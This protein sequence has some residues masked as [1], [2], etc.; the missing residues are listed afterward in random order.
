MAGPDLREFL[1]SVAGSKEATSCIKTH[2]SIAYLD[3]HSGQHLGR[4]EECRVTASKG[5]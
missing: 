4:R 2:H 3:L 5:T 1:V